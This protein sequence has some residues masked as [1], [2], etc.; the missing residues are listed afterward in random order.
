MNRA[1]PVVPAH[2]IHSNQKWCQN[3]SHNNIK[4]KILGEDVVV[5]LNVPTTMTMLDVICLHIMQSWDDTRRDMKEIHA[6]DNKH[7]IVSLVWSRRRLYH[8][9]WHHFWLSWKQFLNGMEWWWSDNRQPPTTNVKPYVNFITWIALP[10]MGF[11]WG[12][13]LWILLLGFIT[14]W[15]GAVARWAWSVNWWHFSIKD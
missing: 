13:K 8:L 7:N 3:R 14:C 2:Q 10:F 6:D 11:Y 12:S 5:V 15:W 9:V 1:V 4:H